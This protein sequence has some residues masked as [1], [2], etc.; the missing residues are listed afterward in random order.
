MKPEV[1]CHMMSSV[2]GRLLPSRWTPPFDGSDPSKLFKQYAVIGQKS[3]TDAWMFGKATACEFFPYRFTPKSTDHLKAG[4]IHIGHRES[5]R[6]F[7]TNV[8]SI[9]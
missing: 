6:L 7:I 1:I 2:D 3:D 8:S 4:K 5:S 9:C